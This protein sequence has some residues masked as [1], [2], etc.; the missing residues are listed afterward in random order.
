MRG[1]L[2]TVIPLR[3]S[4]PQSSCC[5]RVTLHARASSNLLLDRVL[6]HLRLKSVHSFAGGL[7]EI[8]VLVPR[9]NR[10]LGTAQQAYTLRTKLWT[11]ASKG[12]V[13][14]RSRDEQYPLLTLLLP[15][16]FSSERSS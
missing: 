14:Q 2:A 4:L 15:F 3:P 5:A 10:F 12:Y 8:G 13:I 1:C 7:I 9:A 16:L 6:S 11:Q